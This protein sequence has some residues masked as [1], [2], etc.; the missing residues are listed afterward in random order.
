MESPLW[1]RLKKGPWKKIASKVERGERLT[2]EEGIQLAAS[3]DLLALGLMADL[4]RRLRCGDEV[5]FIRN[6]HINYTNICKNSCLFC[7]F[8]RSPG[9]PQGYILSLEEIE[10]RVRRAAQ[11]GIRE[12][13][14]V[15][16]LNPDLPYVYFIDLVR[17]VRKAAPDICIQAFDAVEIDFIAS[18]GKKSIEETLG[19]LKEAGLDSLPG[20]GAEVFSPSLR[21]LLCPQK[22]GAEKWL[23]IH[24]T[25]HG[26]GIPTNAT[27]LY[28][29]LETASERVDHLLALRDLQDRTGGFLAFIPLAFHP[30]NTPLAHL[31]GPTGVEHLKM[32]A[33]SRLLLDNFRH[34]KA[35]WIMMG[36]N[37][38]QISLHFGA[39]DLDGTVLE[40]KIFHEAG[41]QTP[42]WQPA[43]S[44]LHCIFKAGRIPVER[45][46]LYREVRRYHH[47]EG[48]S[49]CPCS[50]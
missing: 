25:A 32:L 45:D 43:E 11:T 26:L 28:G 40:E 37:L 24:E 8:G 6:L 19:E 46:T 15:G 38:A 23:K 41:A 29:H 12:V 22:T 17:T 14:I 7:A 35:F 5:Y 21:R 4:A 33:L 50:G 48:S 18:Q 27:M 1:Q 2:R 44:F 13:H 16:G 47:P 39:N 34:I 20:G 31:P 36:L 3:D 42:Q 9:H 10:G 30:Q 49:P